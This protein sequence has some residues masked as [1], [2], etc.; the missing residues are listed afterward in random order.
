MIIIFLLPIALID[1]LVLYTWYIY[2]GCAIIGDSSPNLTLL[3]FDDCCSKNAFFRYFL[4]FL[5][6]FV[7]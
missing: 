7:L 5:L 3:R 1:K 2:T 6:P 4:Q